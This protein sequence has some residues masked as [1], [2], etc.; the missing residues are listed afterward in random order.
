MER[1]I[2]SIDFW[3]V[4]LFSPL[5][6]NLHSLVS[7]VNCGKIIQ[8]INTEVPFYLSNTKCSGTKVLYKL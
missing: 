5:K 7:L 1:G 8:I 6:K 3:F 4:C 2:H